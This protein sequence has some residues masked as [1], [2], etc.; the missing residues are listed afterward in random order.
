[1]FEIRETTAFTEWLSQ[2]KDGR[3]KAKIAVRIQ[4]MTNGSRRLVVVSVNYASTTAQVIGSISLD[5][6]R[7]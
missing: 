3:A 6:A 4:R 2:L 7:S 5:G 1:M